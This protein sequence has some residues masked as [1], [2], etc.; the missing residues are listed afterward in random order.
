MGPIIIWVIINLGYLGNQG[1]GRIREW[2]A[3][4]KGNEFGLLPNVH[5]RGQKNALTTP[6]RLSQ[7]RQTLRMSK[8]KFLKIRPAER[9][10]SKIPSIGDIQCTFTFYLASSIRHPASRRLVGLSVPVPGR[11]SITRIQEQEGRHRNWPRRQ[12]Y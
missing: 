3:V 11:R 12:S 5:Q 10:W 6:Q 1:R 8:H 4:L 7:T 9:Y 2:S